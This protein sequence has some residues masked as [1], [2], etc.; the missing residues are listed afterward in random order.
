VVVAFDNGS[1]PGTISVSDYDAAAGDRRATLSTGQLIDMGPSLTVEALHT[2]AGASLENNNSNVIKLTYGANS[3]LV[4]GDCETECESSFDPGATQVYKVHH[5]GAGDSSSEAFLAQMQPEVALISVGNGNPYDH[6]SPDT[7]ARLDAVG[8]TIFRTDLDGDLEVLLDGTSWTVNGEAACVDAEVEVCGSID[9]GECSLGT[10]TCSGGAWG[11]CEGA[12]EPVAED[13][14]NGLDDDCDGDADATDP[15]CA[16][17]STA[18]QLAQVAYDT[19]GT[20]S[21]EE[22]VDL[23]NPTGGDVALDGWTLA[24]GAGTWT[25]PAGTTIAAGAFFTVA[26]DA[27]GLEAWVAVVPD[28]DGLTLSLNNGGDVLVLS[29]DQGAGV[30][31]V[32]WESYDPAWG[33]TAGSG[34]SLIRTVPDIDTDSAADW[35]TRSPAL[36]DGGSDS[37]GGTGG[38]CGDGVCDAGEDCESCSADCA[39]QTS[40]RRAD[41]YCCG[42]GTCESV[43][44]DSGTCAVDCG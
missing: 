9:V 12:V 20:D 35:S 11:A 14:S 21:V 31:R 17:T 23:Y 29:D 43:G 26:R 10:R 39:G 37:T 30:D 16:A 19:P 28:L 41:R 32:Y 22:F 15:D 24:D 40:G 44:E 27:A 33:L 13:C 5:H 18:L 25:F 7:L 1:D 38:S 34:D 36:P 2:Q 3:V 8:A 6:P 42:N 4:G